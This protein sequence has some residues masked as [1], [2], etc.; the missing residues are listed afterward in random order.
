MN[1]T[2]TPPK[3]ICCPV[4]N[5]ALKNP[6]LEIGQITEIRMTKHRKRILEKLIEAYPRRVDRDDV[7]DAIYFDHPK[8]GP[9]WATSGLAALVC[10]FNKQLTKFGWIIKGG[11]SG[12]GYTPTLQLINISEG[13]E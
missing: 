11:K 1:I 13:A 7:L 4:C 9:E 3:T 2:V 10:E 8:D 5:Q 12:T 6:A